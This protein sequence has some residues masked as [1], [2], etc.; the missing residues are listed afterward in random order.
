M[1]P[2]QDKVVKAVLSNA[3]N[4]RRIVEQFIEAVGDPLAEDSDYPEVDS[5]G[6]VSFE[7]VTDKYKDY[8][9]LELLEG[10]VSA[11]RMEALAEGAELSPEEKSIYTKRKL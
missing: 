5:G 2:S 1:L 4:A 6:F 10:H 11:Q 3:R 7:D 8:E 9:E